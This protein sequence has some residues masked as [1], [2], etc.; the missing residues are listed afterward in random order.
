MWVT[1]WLMQGRTPQ[2]EF[3][4][5]LSDWRGRM[6]TDACAALSEQELDSR[7][8]DVQGRDFSGFADLRVESWFE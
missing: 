6:A 8:G 4:D 1:M 7:R 2:Q 5:F 3:I